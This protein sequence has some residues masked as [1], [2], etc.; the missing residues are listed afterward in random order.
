MSADQIDFP[1][2]EWAIARTSLLTTIGA[3]L[4]TKDGRRCG[5]A[6]TVE[7][8]IESHGLILAKVITDAGSEMLL[9]ENE[10]GEL[11][12]QPEYVMDISTAPGMIVKVHKGGAA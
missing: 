1:L 8:P 11:F 4:R 3:Q 5:N 6:V 9:T 2:P 10:L 7:F 12:Y